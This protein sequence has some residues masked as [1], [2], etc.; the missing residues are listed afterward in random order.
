MISFLYFF[1]VIGV[2][3]EIECVGATELTDIDSMLVLGLPARSN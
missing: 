3:R 2:D 1:F